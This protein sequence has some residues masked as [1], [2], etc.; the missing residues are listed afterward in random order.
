MEK[1]TSWTGVDLDQ[2]RPPLLIDDEVET[3][4]DQ[5]LTPVMLCHRGSDPP[6][7]RSHHGGAVR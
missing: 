1:P 6:G 2:L 4:L 5:A 3:E 7:Q